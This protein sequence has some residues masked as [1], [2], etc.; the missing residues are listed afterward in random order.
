MKKND[1][2][3]IIMAVYNAA[4]FLHDSIESLMKQTY[5]EI[6][7]ICVDDGSTD[8]SKAII[9][10]YAR[11]DARIR[12][13]SLEKNSGAAVARNKAV[14]VMTGDLVA[15]LDA[16]DWMEE[17]AIEAAVK[18]FDDNPQTDTVLFTCIMQR[19]DG[20]QYPYPQE[21]FCW[22]SGYDAFV[23]SLTWA[24]HGIYMARASLYRQYP[25]DTTCRTFSDDNTTRLHYYISREVRTCEG[26]YF[27]RYNP[28][29]ISHNNTVSRLDYLRASEAMRR[30]LSH[31]SVSDDVLRL[32]ERQHW[33]IIIDAYMFY[34]RNRSHFSLADQIYCLSEIKRAWRDVNISFLP[35]GLKWK[36]GYMPLRFSWSLFRCQ[37]ECYFF[38]KSFLIQ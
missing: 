20:K 27:Y 36:F 12:L 35:F 29:G 32:Y 9:E 21:A 19:P 2:V 6:E 14:E 13:L 31:L 24:I 38:F 37:E 16:D 28:D 17:R 7:I 22:K 5:K 15:F 11:Q 3:T 34:Y 25:Y 4:G 33:L 23:D 10:N 26:K 8:G 18:V 1:R 30:H